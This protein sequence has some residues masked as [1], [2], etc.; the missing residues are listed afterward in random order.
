MVAKKSIEL[1][2]RRV[3]YLEQGDGAETVLFVHGFPESSLLWEQALA[4]AAGLGF[5]ALAPDLPGFGDSERFEGEAST[6]E[7]YVQFLTEFLAAL[8]IEHVHLVVHDWGGPIG[9]RWACDHPGRT[10]SL[11]ITDTIYDPDYNWH[12]NAQYFRTPGVGEQVMAKLGDA[13]TFRA[14]L[15]AAIPGLSDDVIAD[16]HKNVRDASAQQVPLDLYR[17]GDLTKLK[18]YVGK[19][20]ELNLPATI[21]TGELDK[22]VPVASLQKFHEQE[23][24]DAAFHVIA[25]AGHFIHLE[26]PEKVNPLL[27]DHLTRARH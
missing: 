11:F 23:L 16:F 17:S 3:A 14:F 12:E 5:R 10:K 8:Q 24:P 22:Y 7:R 2:N 13:D 26:V 6:W 19:L 1:A 9:L 15:S 25:G 20:K 4:T 21:V 18:P 27:A